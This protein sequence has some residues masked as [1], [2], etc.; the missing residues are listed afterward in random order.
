MARCRP[1]AE[2]RAAMPFAD[3]FGVKEYFI[4]TFRLSLTYRTG[5]IE[6]NSTFPGSK[7]KD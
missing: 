2:H 5:A 7:E 4:V 3:P 1:S 6:R